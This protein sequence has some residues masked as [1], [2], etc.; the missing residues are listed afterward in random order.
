MITPLAYL[1]IILVMIKALIVA[2]FVHESIQTDCG[3][4]IKPI[5]LQQTP[6]PYKLSDLEPYMSSEQLNLH[7]NKHHLSYVTNFNSLLD[8]QNEAKDSGDYKSYIDI[9][10]NLKF[11]GGGHLNHEFFW[12]SLIP[13]SK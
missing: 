11:N 9:I 5:Y 3:R 7:Y 12:Q 1:L 2:M 10:S 4:I 13:A 8:K 6:L